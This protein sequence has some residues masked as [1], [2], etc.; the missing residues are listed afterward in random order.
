VASAL[1]SWVVDGLE[2]GAS[3][4]VAVHVE[5]DHIPSATTPYTVITLSAGPPRAP[6]GL[7]AS[8][9]APGSV[10]LSWTNNSYTATHF[11]VQQMEPA[12]SSWQTI[13]TV[14]AT[15]TTTLTDI[16]HGKPYRYRVIA[17]NA[18]GPSS[19]SDYVRV[20][21]DFGAPLAPTNVAVEVS[22]ST[23]HISWTDNSDN[24]SGFWI[25]EA[26]D[27][28]AFVRIGQGAA[29]QTTF[30]ATGVMS[31]DQH[32][33]RVIAFNSA[34]EAASAD[35]APE[36][37]GGA[38]DFD[39]SFGNAGTLTIDTQP[40]GS[41]GVVALND[42]KALVFNASAFASSLWLTRLNADGTTDIT[43]GS[44]GVLTIVPPVYTAGFTTTAQARS[45]D[46]SIFLW[47]KTLLL[48]LDAH[49]YVDYSFGTNGFVQFPIPASS[50]T[51]TGVS[52]QSD[53]SIF[54]AGLSGSDQYRGQFHLCGENRF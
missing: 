53:G 44:Q 23:Y 40:A 24:E 4:E 6:S 25:E 16:E 41:G 51:V 38:G 11:V 21:A 9:D 31:A 30:A 35:V 13:R 46:D 39:H 49:G 26:T 3:Y 45:E 18:H 17:S 22:T 10:T 29:G 8:S 19:P 34:G 7:Q 32:R 5:N 42:R 15:T 28:G 12:V 48:K 33:Y 47:T 1:T 2:P 50:G 52:P 43:Y 36:Q 14:S 27:Q 54:V 37:E 20:A